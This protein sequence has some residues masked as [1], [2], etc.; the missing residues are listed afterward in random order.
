LSRVTKTTTCLCLAYLC[1]DN[2][3]GG[4]SL[5]P[6]N[7]HRAKLSENSTNITLVGQKWLVNQWL[8][9]DP[10][11]NPKGEVHGSPTAMK[12]EHAEAFVVLPDAMLLGA[13]R[14]IAELGIQ[15][16]L[17]SIFSAPEHVEAGGLMGYGV[18]RLDIF[19]RAATYVDKILRGA[20]PAD[21]PIEQPM[22]FDLVVNMQTATALGLK[23]PS[24]ILIF[25][26]DTFIQS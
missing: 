7:T 8:G 19:R 22:M 15:H 20:K 6:A 10:K 25:P 13:R 1:Y 26:F 23:V 4:E 5:L 17:P 2:T 24:A 14:R 12:S 9:A 16:R 11:K 18:N 21:L 3:L